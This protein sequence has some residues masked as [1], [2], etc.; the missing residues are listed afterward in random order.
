MRLR[1]IIL[2]L[3]A[4]VSVLLSTATG[5]AT[6]HEKA[7]KF[8]GE[9]RDVSMLQRPRPVPDYVFA[10]GDGEKR[11]LTDF[12][13]KVVFL[14]LWATWCPPCVKEMPSLD[15][16]QSEL[17]SEQFEVV[18]LSLDQSVDLVR[19][20]YN[21]FQLTN[22]D[23]YMADE[24]VMAAL[25]AGVLPTTFFIGPKGRILGALAGPAEWDSEEAKNFARYL[26]S[27]GSD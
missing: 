21:D 27:G 12:A 23:F 13:G 19:R 20:F 11:T 24:K 8:G 6:W 9:L 26:I 1:T 25:A 17:G 4:V 10:T 2:T 3:A 18:A 22:L 5:H 7:P 14:N 15:R 16:L